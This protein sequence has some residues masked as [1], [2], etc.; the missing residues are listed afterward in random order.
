MVLTYTILNNDSYQNV[1][2]VLKAHFGISERLLLRLKN[3]KKIFLNGTPTY[4]SNPVSICDNIQVHIDFVEDNSNIIP[5][6][7]DLNILYEDECY[8]VLNKAPNIAIHPSML[9]Y[10]SSLSNGI[11]YY[12]DSINLHKKI[13]PVNRLDKDTSGLVVF[14]KNEYIQECLV[15]QMKSKCMKKTYIAV[16][17]RHI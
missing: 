6:K 5:K 9:H 12:F 1:K 11:K 4:V 13:R 14:A 8:L 2:E 17:H 3:S 10:E 15:A 16:C 7:M